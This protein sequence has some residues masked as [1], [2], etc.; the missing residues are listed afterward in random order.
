MP[1]ERIEMTLAVNGEVRATAFP[2]RT[3]EGIENQ[4]KQWYFFYGLKSVK[5]W[6]IYIS[7]RS[8][9]KECT[10]FKIMKPFPYYIKSQQNDTEQE[11]GPTSLYCEPVNLAGGLIEIVGRR[12][13]EVL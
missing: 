11:S 1:S 8:S 4:R 13:S 10:P 7:H 5:D 6:E 12:Q 9:M 2:Q 3:Y